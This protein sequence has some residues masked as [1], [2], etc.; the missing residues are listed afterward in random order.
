MNA[1][2]LAARHGR[3]L[4]LRDFAL[5]EKEGLGER[6]RDRI[7]VSVG[8]VSLSLRIEVD[9]MRIL[10]LGAHVERTR[11]DEHEHDGSIDPTNKLAVGGAY[12]NGP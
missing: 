4:G 3:P 9:A 1:R 11:R 7:A 8:L 2:I 5:R 6:H 12:W 10:L